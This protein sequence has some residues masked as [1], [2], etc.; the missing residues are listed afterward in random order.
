MKAYFVFGRYTQV[1][2][3]KPE[4]MAVLHTFLETMGVPCTQVSTDQV[5]RMYSARLTCTDAEHIRQLTAGNEHTE[6]RIQ[7]ALR[8]DVSGSIL[9]GLAGIA[10]KHEEKGHLTLDDCNSRYDLTE[11]MLKEI[12]HEFGKE[13][14]DKIRELF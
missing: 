6:A 7:V 1:C 4:Q 10:K 11:A 5:L 9:N 3:F 14:S 13:E 12:G 2:D 8:Y